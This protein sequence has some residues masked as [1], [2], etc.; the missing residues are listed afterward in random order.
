MPFFV[1]PDGCRIHYETFG[2]HGPPVMLIP[3]LGGDGRFWNGVVEELQRHFRLTVVDHRGAGR[4]DRP[5]G[6]Y[7]I[8]RI[9]ADFAAIAAAQGEPVHIVGHSTGGAIA[10]TLALDHPGVG[11]SFTISSSWARADERFRMLFIARAELLEAG[12]AESYQRMTHVFGHE[13]EYLDAHAERFETAVKAA[14]ATLS[15]LDVTAGRVRMLLDHDRL[16]DLPRIDRPVHVIAADADILTPPYLSQAVSEAIPGSQ[17]TMLT[18]AHFHPKD[19]PRQFAETIRHFI[20]KVR[21]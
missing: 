10:Q 14:P 21:T 6:S 1:A 16:V 4:S 11:L 13:A 20:E 12:L 17:F 2:D 15:P 9:S 18:G 8:G 5:E 19:R 3:G 7:S